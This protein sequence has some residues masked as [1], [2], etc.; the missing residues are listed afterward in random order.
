MSCNIY[1]SQVFR[2]VLAT[3]NRIPDTDVVVGCNALMLSD[4]FKF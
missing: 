4:Y 2:L 1:Y 3:L